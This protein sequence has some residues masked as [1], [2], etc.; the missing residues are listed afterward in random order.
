MSHNIASMIFYWK[1]QFNCHDGSIEKIKIAHFAMNKY[2]D[3]SYDK[4]HEQTPQTIFLNFHGPLK[5]VFRFLLFF[6]NSIISSEQKRRSLIQLNA[7]CTLWHRLQRLRF[8]H[9]AF[10]FNCKTIMWFSSF[11]FSRS[12]LPFMRFCFGIVAIDVC[13]RSVRAHGY[14]MY[15][16]SLKHLDSKTFV[17]CWKFN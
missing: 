11:P 12:L 3:T 8:T 4:T 10:D 2:C 15:S 17:L 7:F 9:L 1:C 13:M 5:I 16:P 6:S 14:V